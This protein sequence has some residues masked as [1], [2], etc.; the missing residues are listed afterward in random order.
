MIDEAAQILDSDLPQDQSLDNGQ[1]FITEEICEHWR[2]SS[3]WAFIQ[4]IAGVVISLFT[5]LLQ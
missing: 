3:K 1:L 2:N 5:P 4:I